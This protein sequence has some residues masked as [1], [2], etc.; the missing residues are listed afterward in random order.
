MTPRPMLVHKLI[1]NDPEVAAYAV[2][3]GVG[4]IM[5]DIERLG[6]AER[7]A[8]RSTVIS[9]HQISD[10]ARIRTAVPKADILLR[11]NPWHAGSPAEI[12]AGISAGANHLMLPMVT[13][14]REVAAAAAGLAG[15]SVGLIPLIETPAA[16]VRLHRIVRVPGVSEIYIGL[17]DLHLGLGLR[18]MFEI[19]ASGL[20][21]QMTGV[22]RAAGLPFG[23]GGIATLGGGIVP[24]HLVLAEHVRLGSTRVILAHAFSQG[25]TTVA[26]FMRADLPGE[27]QK[28]VDETADLAQADVA[29]KHRELQA[30]VQRHVESLPC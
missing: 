4:R 3:S 25:A 8:G 17:N 23:F 21:E 11:I 30:C 19:V 5:V 1:T 15:T 18:F 7:Q 14:E 22:V 12:S 10:V 20:L 26:D 13:S 24:A 28:L 6:K 29:A 2:A 9:D 27:I 16:M